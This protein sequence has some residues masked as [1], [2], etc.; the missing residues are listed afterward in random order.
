[1]PHERVRF[2]HPGPLTAT[3]AQA[4]GEACQRVID[5]DSYI[6]G[7]EVATFEERW[8][9]FLGAAGA[10]GVASGLDALEVSLR[11]L[12]VG[13]GDEV[14]VP[15]MSAMATALAVHRAGAVPVFCDISAATALI[16]LDQL[17][18]LV[19]QRTRA[20]IPVH[21]Y[22]RAVDMPRL[23]AWAHDRS[24]LVVEDVAQ[25]HGARVGGRCVGTWGEAGAFSFYPTKNLGALGDAGAL[26]SMDQS[27][28][29]TA[30]S[31]RNYG[32]RAQYDHALLG[33]NSRLDE[34]QAA[35][36]SSRL[37]GLEAHTKFRQKV[38]QA[39]FTQIEN[40]HVEL[41][42]SP[43]DPDTYVAHIFA[44][45]VGNREHFIRHMSD[46][47]I[48]CL[49]HYPIPLPD[50]P[51]ASPWLQRAPEIPTARRHASTCVSLPC[52]PGLSEQ[53][54][55]RVIDATNAYRP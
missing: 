26:V 36:L 3:E 34:M 16:D 17:D 25:A 12:D 47:G 11:A 41:M 45:R 23:C 44:V 46:A 55:Q 13:P 14:I 19:T 29:E 54:V 15:A 53:A 35:I 7:P 2:A 31:L 10:V 8:A 51:A 52:R 28:L 22:G 33:L 30:R 5:S 32:Q 20:V 40:T 9:G 37:P 27:L 18:L 42:E 50:Q 24:L 38:A 48:D 49:I 39:Y 4:L 21:L 1:M 43:E 6:L